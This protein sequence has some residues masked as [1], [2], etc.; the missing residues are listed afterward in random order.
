MWDLT[1]NTDDSQFTFEPPKDA[2]SIPWNQTTTA[3]A[4]SAQ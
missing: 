1:A 3:S 2:K 4:R